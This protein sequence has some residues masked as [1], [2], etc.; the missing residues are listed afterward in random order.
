MTRVLY[1]LAGRDGHMFSPYCWRTIMALA[2][3][4]L[5]Y[6]R[7]PM[8]FTD[9]SPI[10]ASGQER[11]PVLEED[12]RTIADSWTIA[13]H[14]EDSYPDR[15]SLFA[16]AAARAQ[17]LFFNRWVDAAV[18]P[19]L[20]VILVP[21]VHGLTH[22]DDTDWF[23]DNRETTFG[24]SLDALRRERPVALRRLAAV[25]EPVRTTLASEDFLSGEAPAYA[26][27]ILFGSLMWAR[28]SSPVSLLAPDDPIHAWR[29]RMLDL[30][31]GLAAKAPGYD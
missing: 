29:A 12:G 4:R 2:H 31:D 16:C 9:R 1:E 6:E 14:L 22:P 27:Y 24:R 23:K 5:D 8:K 26:D 18:H 3:K 15:P 30:F 20:R 10:A 19:E 11:V 13:C 21:D 7:V 17:A 25:L 28:S